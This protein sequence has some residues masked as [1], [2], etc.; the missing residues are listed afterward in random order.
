MN[1]RRLTS[2][3]DVLTGE[4]ALVRRPGSRSRSEV[5]LVMAAAAAVVVTA[6]VMLAGIVMLVMKPWSTP[7]PPIMLTLVMV[8]VP[9]TTLAAAY[10]AA[11][12][13]RRARDPRDVLTDRE[14][15]AAPLALAGPWPEASKAARAIRAAEGHDSMR[16]REVSEMLWEMAERLQTGPDLHTRIPV[17]TV[18]RGQQAHDQIGTAM[19]DLAHQL[20]ARAR[21]SA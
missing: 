16:E 19:Q 1:L 2:V 20:T 6:L 14:I 8:E 18:D 15:A 11:I 21:R 17:A 4:E 13:S 5:L 3:L 9:V 12:A 10:V 7:Q